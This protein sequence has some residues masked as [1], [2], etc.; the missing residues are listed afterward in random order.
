MNFSL[1]FIFCIVLKNPIKKEF[2]I[3]IWKVKFQ[4]IVGYLDA[5][6]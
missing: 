5:L 4:K 3:C 2:I 6:A 1:M